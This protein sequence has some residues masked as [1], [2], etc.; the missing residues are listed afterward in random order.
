MEGSVL[1]CWSQY[2]QIRYNVEG[3]KSLSAAQTYW[4]LHMGRGVSQVRVFLRAKSSF[5]ATHF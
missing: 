1:H 5:S 3:K 4:R 2:T